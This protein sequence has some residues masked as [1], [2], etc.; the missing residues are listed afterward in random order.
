[1]G[2]CAAA[3]PP[4][5]DSEIVED[6][7]KEAK[8]LEPIVLRRSIDAP[9]DVVWATLTADQSFARL[10][11]DGF[12]PVPGVDRTEIADPEAGLVPGNYHTAYL[13]RRVGGVVIPA[14]QT[15]ETYDEVKAP[16]GLA[17]G[18]FAYTVTGYPAPFPAIVTAGH[19]LFEIVP[20]GP[21]TTIVQFTYS[22]EQRDNGVLN[23]VTRVALRTAML[24]W[25]GNMA[26]AMKYLEGLSEGAEE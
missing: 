21:T 25:K 20:K 9:A 5:G 11:R 12:G 15:K 1:L 10:F 6:E 2:G 13:V 16:S 18:R 3:A 26:G 14:G 17:E 23:P 7:F 4:E 22:F 24:A 19:G 8:P